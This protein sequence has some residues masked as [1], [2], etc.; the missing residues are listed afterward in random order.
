M[1]QKIMCLHKIIKYFRKRK[2]ETEFHHSDT[3][4]N[5]MAMNLELSPISCG[6][7]VLIWTKTTAS[8]P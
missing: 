7:L 6:S 5:Y 3:G 1:F 2:T 8:L 4:F